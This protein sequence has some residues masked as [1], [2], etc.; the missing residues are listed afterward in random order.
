MMELFTI[1]VGVSGGA[2]DR[3]AEQEPQPQA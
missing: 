1:G 2:L 3:L